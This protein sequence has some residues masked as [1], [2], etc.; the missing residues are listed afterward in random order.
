MCY[1]GDVVYILF[2]WWCG[3]SSYGDRAISSESYRLS[4]QL[5]VHGSYHIKGEIYNACVQSVLKYVTEAREMKE[6]NLKSLQTT[7]STYDGEM[8]VKCP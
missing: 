1:L 5:D 4:Q 7:E 3:G 2:R 6:E 8:N